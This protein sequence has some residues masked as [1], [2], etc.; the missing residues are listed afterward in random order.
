MSHPTREKHVILPLRPNNHANHSK[1]NIQTQ[2]NAQT[3]RHYLYKCKKSKFPCESLIVSSC[4][5]RGQQFSCQ[6]P[7]SLLELSRQELF[8]LW[9]ASFRLWEAFRVEMQV[10]G[11]GIR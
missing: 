5:Q 11:I 6:L 2:Q 9:W 8:R 1:Q 7:S 10:C 3:I 4:H